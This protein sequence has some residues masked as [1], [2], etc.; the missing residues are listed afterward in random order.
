MLQAIILVARIQQFD[1]RDLLTSRAAAFWSAASVEL[2]PAS[3]ECCANLAFKFRSQSQLLILALNS[4]SP[5]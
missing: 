1:G 2:V 3:V 5:G 4:S